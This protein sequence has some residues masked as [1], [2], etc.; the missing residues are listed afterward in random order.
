[1]RLSLDGASMLPRDGRPNTGQS[2]GEPRMSASLTRRGGGTVLIVCPGGLEH[3]GG[4]GRQ[5]GYFLHAEAANPSDLTYEVID[6]R[7]PWFLGAAQRQIGAA[8][9]YL[10]GAMVKLLKARVASGAKIAHINI[11]GRGSTL[12]K[13][14]LTAFCRS[15]RLRYLL[16][17]HD[18]DYA[19]EYRK[20][21]PLPRFMIRRT[22]QGAVTTLVL[23]KRDL[24]LL[25]DLLRLK[26]NQ[27]QVLHNAVPDPGLTENG[28]GRS[29]TTCRLLFLGHLSDRKGVPELLRALARPDLMAKDWHATLAGGGPIDLY[30]GLAAELGIDHR[31][32]FPGWVDQAAVTALCVSS[33][34][35]VLPSY[36]EGM[37]MSVLEGL[38]HGLAVVT[39]PVGAHEEVIEPEQSGLLV[40][41][42]D[43]DALADALVRVIEDTGYRARLRAGARQRFL[44]AFDVRGYRERL[45]RIHKSFL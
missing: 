40:P 36:A 22:F 14:V 23:G 34:V 32:D 31:I 1:M 17:V 19:D 30:R 20:R 29:G 25:T 12:R 45:I 6:S 3:G 35:L 7:G 41:P 2:D 15:I 43:V 24:G 21:G 44:D 11:T 39:T 28:P 27:I 8:V 33:D 13:V 9:M 42:G 10:S 4:I 38:S 18:F 37:A 26:P 16:H 5:M